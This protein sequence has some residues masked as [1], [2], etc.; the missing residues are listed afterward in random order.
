VLLDNQHDGLLAHETEQVG[1]GRD[2]SSMVGDALAAR[3]T[4]GSRIFC[5]SK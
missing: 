2:G 1:N 5:V 3:P 4:L